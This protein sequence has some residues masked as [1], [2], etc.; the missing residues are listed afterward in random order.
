MHGFPT[1]DPIYSIDNYRYD[2]PPESIA[3]YPAE[4][5]DSCRLLVMDRQTG[6]L[7]DR[8]FNEIKHL[9]VSGDT[10]VL[11]QTKVIPA[12]L[13]GVKDTG[14]RIEILL[15]GQEEGLWEALVKPARRMKVGSI[16]RFPGFPDVRAEVVAVLEGNGCRQLRFHDCPDINS[17]LEL[18][19]QVPLPPYIDRHAEP[20]DLVRYQTVYAREPGSA[21]A[22]TAGLH[23][24]AGLLE[25]IK[26]RGIEVVTLVLHVGLGTFRPVSSPD[27]RQHRMHFE[28]YYVSP[29]TAGILN[30]NRARGG[31]IVAVGTTVVRTLESVYSDQAGFCSGSGQTDMFIYPGYRF[32]AIDGLI[33][34]F[35]LPCSSL[36]MLVGAFGGLD[37]T[38]AAYRHAVETGYRF[39]SYGDAMFITAT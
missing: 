29:D 13:I 34:N 16:V 17:F 24:T 14:A 12:R 18:A 5:R 8:V 6:S 19:G 28:K 21:A 26:A 9:L 38:M 4:P 23:F 35:H 30:R 3:Q 7:Q 25:E 27:I 10:L 37:N 36:L 22:P 2:L 15:L 31:R 1:V 39:F 33:T 20:D 32:K 11:N